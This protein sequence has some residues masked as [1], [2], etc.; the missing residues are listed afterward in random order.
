MECFDVY[1]ICL[2]R[3]VSISLQL[4]Y[5]S[6]EVQAERV[7]MVHCLDTWG[8]LKEVE[9]ESFDGRSKDVVQV[10][11]LF[12]LEFEWVFLVRRQLRIHIIGF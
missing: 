10:S 4:D 5:E 9:E 8:W 11:E 1:R 7:H 12:F 6:H 2:D 3:L